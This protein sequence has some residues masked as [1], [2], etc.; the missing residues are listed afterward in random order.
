M[1][2]GEVVQ[3]EAYPKPPILVVFDGN[4]NAISEPFD[5]EGY[6]L[7]GIQIPDGWAGGGTI[8][9]LVAEKGEPETSWNG[10]RSA[11]GAGAGQ[12]SPTYLPLKSASGSAVQVTGVVPGTF[13]ALGAILELRGLRYMKLQAAVGPAVKTTLA[14]TRVQYVQ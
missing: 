10:P 3:I 4:G 12:A 11:A 7:T 9:F 2:S 5:T 13:V 6:N 14:A 8:S 1:A